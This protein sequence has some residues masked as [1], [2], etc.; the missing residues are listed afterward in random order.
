[1]TE[2]VED[3]A[4]DFRRPI[5]FG[6]VSRFRRVGGI[7]PVYEALLARGD[8]VRVRLVGTDE[9]FDYPLLDAELDPQA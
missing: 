7:G 8:R 3:E 9:E 5:D 2:G 6:S 4:A 1:M